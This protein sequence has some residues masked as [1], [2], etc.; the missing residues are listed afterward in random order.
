MLPHMHHITT[1]GTGCGLARR[2]ALWIVRPLGCGRFEGGVAGVASF[3]SHQI[4]LPNNPTCELVYARAS[5]GDDRCGGQSRF[6][7]GDMA[8]R[9]EPTGRTCAD[10]GKPITYEVLITEVHGAPPIEMRYGP[11]CWTDTCEG[12]H[13]HDDASGRPS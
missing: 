10:C 9:Y 7:I 3:R 2:M 12:K 4:W 1:K 11:D 6:S 8:K 5:R 13:Q